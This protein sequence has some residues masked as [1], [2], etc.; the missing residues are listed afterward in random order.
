MPSRPASNPSKKPTTRAVVEREYGP[1]PDAPRVHGVTFDGE[2]AWFAAGDRMQSFDPRTG[3]PGRSLPIAADAGT[4]FDGKHLFQ[5]AAGQIQKIDPESGRVLSSMP[6]PGG[7]SNASGL[8][9]AEGSLW[10]GQYSDR[11]IL[12]IDPES[13]RVLRTVESD[14]FVTGVTFLDGELWHGTDENDIRELRHVDVNSGAVLSCLVMPEGVDFS[15]LEV[16][17]AADSGERTFLCGG[18]RSGKIRAV[19]RPRE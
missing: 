2:S 19:R 6:A 13:G 3:V 14:R 5:I 7:V 16:A 8:T 4:A 12:Q 15:G 17:S 1:F 11:K 10:V 9:W 18:G